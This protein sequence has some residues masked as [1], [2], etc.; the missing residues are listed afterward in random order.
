MWIGEASGGGFVSF[1]FAPDGTTMYTGDDCGSVLAWDRQTH[2]SR[3]LYEL[4]RFN[5]RRQA[6]WH[7]ALTPAATRLLIPTRYRIE[8]LDLPEGVLARHVLTTPAAVPWLSVSPDGHRIM[9]AAMGLRVEMRD[10]KTLG[11]RAV[12]GALGQFKGAMHATFVE[13]GTRVLVVQSDKYV[14]IWNAKSGRPLGHCR[15]AEVGCRVCAV[16]A[17]GRSFAACSTDGWE[18]VVYGPPNWTRR[19]VIRHA[20]QIDSLAFNPTG[21]L[22][23]ITDGTPDVTLWNA[24]AQQA[25]GTWNWDIG[26]V[27]GVAFAPDGLTCAVGGVGQFAV[28]DVDL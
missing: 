27:R 23:A 11:Q 2:E 17:D 13:G 22:L 7:L 28:F 3:E 25:A 4:D 24:T 5:G 8:A 1:A 12:P 6:V 15:A 10:V 16:S 14:S 18:A 9:M 21:D 26:N 20:R 19:A